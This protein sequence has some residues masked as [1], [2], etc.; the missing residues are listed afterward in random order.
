MPSKEELTLKGLQEFL[1]SHNIK[2]RNNIVNHTVTIEGDLS[3]DKIV[4]DKLTYFYLDCYDGI[5]EEGIYLCNRQL[6]RDYLNRL[7]NAQSAIYNPITDL[8]NS[9]ELD[10]SKD[11]LAELYSIMGIEK[12]DELSKVLIHKWLLQC[13]ALS[14]NTLENAIGADGMLVLQGG[15]G[16]GKTSLIR[17]LGVNS[18]LCKLDCSISEFDKDTKINALT[19]WICE[20]GEFE[21]TVK[22]TSAEMLKVLVT[23]AIDYYRVAYGQ[24]TEAYPRITNLVGTCNHERFLTDDTGSRRYWVV[25]VDKIDLARLEKFDVL[26]LWKQI[27]NEYKSLDTNC[28][29]LTSAEQKALALRNIQHEKIEAEQEIADLIAEAQMLNKKFGWVTSTSFKTANKSISKYDSRTIGKAL[30]KLEIEEKRTGK[31]RF[32]YLPV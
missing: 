18:E 7:L 17:K 19:S 4:R 23:T 2:I 20:L 25:P 14:T 24:R 29:R 10:S 22:G 16:V 32:Y 11:Y 1:N 5:K 6:V 15:Q 28:F 12:T 9:V 27:D 21:K 13:I 26:H 8:L 30:K 3:D 31:G